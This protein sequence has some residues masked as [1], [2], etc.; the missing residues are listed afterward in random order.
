MRAYV[1]PFRRAAVSAGTLV[2]AATTL[3]AVAPGASSA[4]QVSP[5]GS[6]DGVWTQVGAGFAVNADDT[7]SQVFQLTSREQ[8][9]DLRGTPGPIYAAGTFVTSGGPTINR[10]AQDTGG[11]WTTLPGDDTGIAPGASITVQDKIP[12][13]GVYGFALGGN[14][15]LYAG[16]QFVASD[17]TLN[18]VA[19]W[20]G[21]DW[22]KM[23]NGLR[24]TNSAS[25]Y[26]V[27]DMVVG[28]DF[29]GNNDTNYADDTVYALGGFTHTCAT[30]ACTADGRLAT[31][32]AQYSQ[33]DDTWYPVGNGAMSATS[34][35]FAGAYV[36]DTLYV[37]GN[38]SSIGSVSA[39]HIARWNDAAGTWAPLG[40]GLGI[41]GNA[42]YA[43][44]VHPTTKDLYVGGTFGQASGYPVA[45]APGIIKWDYTDDTWYSVGSGLA[46]GNVDDIAFSLDGNTMW[47]G[48]DAG[49]VDGSSAG[50]VAQ[51]TSS[52]LS[53]PAATT[54]TGSWNAITSGGVTGVGGPAAVGGVNQT[55][56]RAVYAIGNDSAM[57]GGNFHTAGAITA[58]RIARWSPPEP[59]P[60]PPPPPPLPSIAPGA[61]SAVTAAAGVQSVTVT[62]TPPSYSGTQPITS[63]RATASP[64]GATCEV[65]ALTCTFTDLTVGTSYTFQVQAFNAVGWGGL[66]A[67][68][69]AASP[70]APPP[71][72]IPVTVS[73]ASAERTVSGRGTAVAASVVTTGVDAGTAVV[74]WTR[75]GRGEWTPNAASTLVVAADGSAEWKRK[76]GANRN[77]LTISIKFEVVGVSSDVTSLRPVK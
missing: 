50:F 73:I 8:F 30:L 57:F 44:A 9:P 62:W 43:M 70:L 64:G 58:G 26:V 17:D 10:V 48:L 71:P 60:P 39:L 77:R 18:N 33:V 31:G 15:W 1:R 52:Q 38:F 7:L 45:S 54:V 34:Q 21:S 46:S 63:Y 37:G 28:N 25:G 51:L 5:R 66:S 49:A 23:G 35:A 56:V 59:P 19:R 29:I 2:L 20:N 16:G 22:V 65:N 76:F 14:N 75:I 4:P 61:P 24:I 6:V 32:V 11:G 36:D 42:V 68:S 67:P 3:V 69:N 27:Q 53:S 74:P 12:S 47:L 13:P 55:S 72:P 41:A 40:G